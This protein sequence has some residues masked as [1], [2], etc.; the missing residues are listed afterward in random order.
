MKNLIDGLREI[1]ES[2]M[3]A[4]Q[5]RSDAV[6]AVKNISEIIEETAGSAETV[7]DVV[8]K[9]L[10]NVGGLTRTA[11]ELGDNM[12]NLKDGISVFKTE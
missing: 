1:M 5:E 6:E 3:K 9:L 4:D 11:D 12:N 2:S 10:Q 8:E 7:R